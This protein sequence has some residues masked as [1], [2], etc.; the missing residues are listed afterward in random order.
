MFV[1]KKGEGHRFIEQNI[2][3][4]F[5]KDVDYS[6]ANSDVSV[7]LHSIPSA[8]VISEDAQYKPG[9][10]DIKQYKLI[11]RASPLQVRAGP[12]P[13]YFPTNNFLPDLMCNTKDVEQCHIYIFFAKYY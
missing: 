3:H 2:G 8:T 5:I 13:F 10:A 12:T 11:D 6:W 7:K 9:N 1:K 4:S